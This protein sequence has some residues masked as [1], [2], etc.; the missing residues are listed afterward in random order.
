[1]T[2]HMIRFDL[3]R[4]PQFPEGSHDHSYLLR[5]PLDASRIVDLTELRKAPDHAEVLRS[6]PD[7][8]E[9][10]GYLVHKH[11][12]WAFSYGPGDDDDEPLFHLEAHPLQIG[13]Y[14]TV[15]QRDGAPLAF[16]VSQNAPLA[17]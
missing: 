17:G 9:M 6:R 7:E 2:W 8:P 11:K 15:T 16:A 3:A 13:A 14:V 4:C 1:M 5:A 12:G 10:R